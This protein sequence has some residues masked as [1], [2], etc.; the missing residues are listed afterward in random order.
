MIFVVCLYKDRWKDEEK[1]I[2]DL[3]YYYIYIKGSLYPVMALN[4]DI[5]EHKAK[6]NRININTIFIFCLRE[7]LSPS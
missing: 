3:L 4:I 2:K 1:S 7:K 6:L 5:G